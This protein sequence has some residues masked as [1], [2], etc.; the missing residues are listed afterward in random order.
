MSLAL[1]RGVAG[2]IALDSLY[3]GMIGARTNGHAL[4]AANDFY[5]GPI[6][7]H[8]FMQ[9]GEATVDEMVRS[10]ARGLLV[11]HFHYTRVV[12][13]L[14]VIITGMTRY[15][16]FLI[17]NGEV[18]RPVKSL[19]YTQSYLDALRDVQAIGRETRLSGERVS[20]RVPALKIG[21]FTFTGVTE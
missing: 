7:L 14:Y 8:L 4:Q 10:T 11:T 3:A 18:T 12:H 21:S 2:D 9:P 19:R 6:P 16:T 17:E 15:G 13:P 1:E 20:A 5:S